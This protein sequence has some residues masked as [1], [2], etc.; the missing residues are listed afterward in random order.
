MKLAGGLCVILP[1]CG[2]VLYPAGDEICREAIG[3][4]I[5]DG[6]QNTEIHLG[7]VT[8]AKHRGIS[9]GSGV[10]RVKKIKLA[11]FKKTEK[12]H[13]AKILYLDLHKSGKGTLKN[14]RLETEF[15]NV[16]A[17]FKN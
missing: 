2:E 5:K 3:K 16:G 11:F 7:Y 6:G 1:S 9:I 8:K 12:E 17:L 14:V 15:V 13:Y 10:W 4:I